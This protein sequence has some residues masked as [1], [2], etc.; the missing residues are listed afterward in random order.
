MTLSATAATVIIPAAAAM[1]ISPRSAFLVSKG[2]NFFSFCSLAREDMLLFSLIVFPGLDKGQYQQE[3]Q[4]IIELDTTIISLERIYLVICPL[5][6]L[7]FGNLF[8]MLLE[9]P[10]YYR[11]CLTDGNPVR[12]ASAFLNPICHPVSPY[13]GGQNDFCNGALTLHCLRTINVT[14]DTSGNVAP[15]LIRLHIFAMICLI[16]SVLLALVVDRGNEGIGLS[17]SSNQKAWSFLIRSI[18]CDQSARVFR[19]PSQRGTLAVFSRASLNVGS[20]Q[21]FLCSPKHPLLAATTPFMDPF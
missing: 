20:S 18:F 3:D 1:S 15:E 6:I 17:L 4:E 14:D 7:I 13:P 5:D 11:G 12:N 2:P 8:A 19:S 21:E 9:H 16:Y 10:D